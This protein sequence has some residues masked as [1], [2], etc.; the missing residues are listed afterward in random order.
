MLS[1][2]DKLQRLA[3]ITDQI[4]REWYERVKENYVTEDESRELGIGPEL[5]YFKD[6]SSYRLKFSRAKELDVTYGL[7]VRQE[8]D[9]LIVES[10]VNNKSDG[11]D[12]ESFVSRL[13]FHYWR[14]SNDKPWTE[15]DFDHFTYQDLLPFD[16]VMGHSVNLD[17]RKEKADIIRLS[18]KINPQ[19]EDLLLDRPDVLRDLIEDYCLAP[20][21][22]IYA[23]CYRES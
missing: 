22:R 12:Y 16:P 5:K 2:E 18:F 21:K 1:K 11:F 4:V 7:S 23:E 10:S 20:L 17:I 8:G 14:A 9:R 15:P 3:Q 13:K 19:H 6:P